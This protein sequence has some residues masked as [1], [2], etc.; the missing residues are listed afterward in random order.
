MANEENL[1]V[2]RSENEARE[3][4]KK[5]GK[6]S[7]KARRQKKA[8]RDELEA[9]LTLPMSKGKAVDVTKA[10]NFKDFAKENKSVR[11][12]VISQLTAQALSGNVKAREQ[13]L[14]LM[15]MVEESTAAQTEKQKESELENNSFINALNGK[16]A[17][18]WNDEKQEE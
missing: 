8:L 16:A 2:I 13:L 12:Q 6:A 14:K 7:G 4:G 15:M 11:M 5:G 10:K 9:L 17:E 18:I 1:K 3:K